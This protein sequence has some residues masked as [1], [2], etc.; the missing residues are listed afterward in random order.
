MTS[1]SINGHALLQDTHAIGKVSAITH[2]AKRTAHREYV[3][4]VIVLA[5]GGALVDKLL[6]EHVKG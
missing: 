3:W 1:R 2:N 4:D 5:E 6:V